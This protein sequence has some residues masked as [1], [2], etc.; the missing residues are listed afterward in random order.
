M[1]RVEILNNKFDTVVGRAV[2]NIPQVMSWTGPLLKE[3]S[4][5]SHHGII[6]LKGGEFRNELDS[7]GVKYELHHISKV[8]SESFFESKKIVRL[9]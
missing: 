3:K 8:F 2:K 7:L 4:N 6:Y 9:Y 5:C 1:S